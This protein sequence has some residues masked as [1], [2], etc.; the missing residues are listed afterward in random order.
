MNLRPQDIAMLQALR[1]RSLRHP[2]SV[3]KAIAALA[4]MEA[5]EITWAQYM[6]ARAEAAALG[7]GVPMLEVVDADTGD[8]PAAA[9]DA[10]PPEPT[11]PPAG[12]ATFR[13]NVGDP[14]SRARAT[15][16]AQVKRTELR[17]GG[18]CVT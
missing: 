14:A 4:T 1:Q 12:G 5:K 16:K 11:P 8:Q 18:P 7:I 2:G 17:G 15:E 10:P 6:R 9:G 13:Y 3:K